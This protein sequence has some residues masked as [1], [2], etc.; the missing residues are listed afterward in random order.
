MK[1]KLTKLLSAGALVAVSALS[2]NAAIII[3][4]V[5]TNSSHPGG[6]G[7][8]DWFEIYNSGPSAVN[9][10]DWSWDDESNAAGTAGFGGAILQPG[11]FLIVVD[12]SDANLPTWINDVWNVD[13]LVSG[14]TLTVISSTQAGSFP[15]LA[16]GG[17]TFYIYDASDALV[18]SA[19]SGSQS[20]P[21][22]GRSFGWSASG[23][24]LGR[25]ANGV[26]GA[27]LALDDGLGAA[28]TDIAS[29]GFAVGAIPEPSAAAALAGLVTL[30]LAASRR[31]RSA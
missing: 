22:A 31:R 4:E 12:E 5:M 2:A 18:T 23:L 20:A 11:A 30:G 9:L 13:S 21:N 15:G 27:F 28:G 19:N 3:T 17:E 29:P 25:S 10:T 7:N 26:G 6:A 1:S 16:A 8:G 14:G 24:D